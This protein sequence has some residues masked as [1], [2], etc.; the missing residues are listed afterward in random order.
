MRNA[1]DSLCKNK[2]TL[3]CY[4]YIEIYV[5]KTINLVIQRLSNQLLLSKNTILSIGLMCQETLL[6][7]KIHL[8]IVFIENQ[9]QQCRT[10]N[11]TSFYAM[12]C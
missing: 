2:F 8:G 3:L 5:A 4:L 10:Y 1:L 9:A 11:Q 6:C 7:F 12:H